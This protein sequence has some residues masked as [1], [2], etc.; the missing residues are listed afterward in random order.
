[1]CHTDPFIKSNSIFSPPR[2]PPSKEI[3]KRKKKKIKNKIKHDN[4]YISTINEQ[5]LTKFMSEYFLHGVL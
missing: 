5:S 2:I 1:M 4:D 3:P